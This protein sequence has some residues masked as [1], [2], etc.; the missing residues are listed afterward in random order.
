MKRWPVGPR[1]LG[2]MARSALGPPPPGRPG[3]CEQIETRQRP[4][5]L[6]TV[7]YTERIKC[8]YLT[9][10]EPHGI[11]SRKFVFTSVLV[12]ERTHF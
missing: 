8:G 12:F 6:F 11:F 1:L 2:I 9:R 10:V 3:V 5:S 4:G 7:N